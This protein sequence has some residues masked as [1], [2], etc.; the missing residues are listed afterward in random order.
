M[1]SVS[2]LTIADLD[3]SVISTE[4][5]GEQHGIEA[6]FIFVDAE[7]GRGPKLHRHAYPEIFIVQEGEV[8]L[9]AD[10][11]EHVARAGQVVIL[12]AGVAHSFKSTGQGRLR[13][14]DIHLHPRF[15]TEWLE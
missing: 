4:L 2:I 15:E 5:V 1:S 11:Q 13:Q 3:P 9:V 7:P 8:T 14:V 6:S 10:G 12:G